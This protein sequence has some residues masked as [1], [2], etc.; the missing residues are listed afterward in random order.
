MDVVVMAAGRGTRLLPLTAS[1]PK[2]MVP[3]FNVPIVDYLCHELTK[4][5]VDRVFMLVDYLQDHMMKHLGDGSK[6]GM[7]IGY[8]TNNEPFGTAGAVNKV[9]KEIKERRNVQ[10][11]RSHR[12]YLPYRWHV[13]PLSRVHGRV[14]L[15]REGDSPD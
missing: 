3:F 12:Q 14:P 6:Y 11:W 9:V 15:G 10:Y 8:Y 1:R 4:L 7:H 5:K 13:L 2:P